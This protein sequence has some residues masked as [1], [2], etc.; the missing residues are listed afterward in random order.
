[1]ISGLPLNNFDVDL[2]EAIL[3]TFARLV[4]PGGM[5]SFFEYIAIRRVRSAVGKR[6]DRERLRGIDQVLG[7]FLAEH[8]IGRELVWRNVPP[9]WVHHARIQPA[10]V[11]S[12]AGRPG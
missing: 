1:V 5:I 2:V 12:A 6:A 11:G 4:R 9:A 8:A 7:R 10:R 3:R